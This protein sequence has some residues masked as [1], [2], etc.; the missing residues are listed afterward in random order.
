MQLAALL[1]MVPRDYV[2]TLQVSICTEYIFASANHIVLIG[3]VYI[4]ESGNN[5][6]RKVLATTSV[7]STIA[8][9][10]EYSYSGDDGPAT[11]ATLRYPTGIA[12]DAAGKY[13]MLETGGSKY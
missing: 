6:V 3:N 11:S 2:S 7:I 8:G 1:L 4:S 9:T 10:G 13:T 12:I 5:V